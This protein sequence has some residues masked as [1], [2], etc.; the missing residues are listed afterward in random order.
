MGSSGN[1]VRRE[2]ADET[3]RVRAAAGLS[4]S[5]GKRVKVGGNR[6]L[7]G[8]G[9]DGQGEGEGIRASG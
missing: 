7:R 9:A 8:S 5:A 1:F 2:W 3:Q 6:G 4:I